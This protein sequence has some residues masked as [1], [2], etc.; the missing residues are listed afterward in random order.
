MA[1]QRLL[2]MGGSSG[3]GAATATRFAQTGA[4]VVITGRNE[5]RLAEVARRIGPNAT[6]HRL[7]AADPAELAAF[8]AADTRYDHLVLAL[9]GAAGGGAFA[10][11]ELDTLRAGF[12]GKFWLHLQTLQAALPRLRASGSVTFVTASSARSALPGTAGLAAI[13]GALEAMVGPLAVELAPLRVN[14]V[15]PGVIDTPWWDAVPAGQRTELFRSYEKSSPVGRSVS[16]KMSRRPY[17][18]SRPMAL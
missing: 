5:E 18:C 16:P 1:T 14:A 9:S 6:A 15:S 7:D 4:E 11:L 10:D 8:F 17:Y 2:V 12:E 13:N 3:I